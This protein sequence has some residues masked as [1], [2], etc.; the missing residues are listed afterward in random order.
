MRL[1]KLLAIIQG[2]QASQIDLGV[3]WGRGTGERKGNRHKEE[4]ILRRRKL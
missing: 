3:G 4:G 2:R 1:L